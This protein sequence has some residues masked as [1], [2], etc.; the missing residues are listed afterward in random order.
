MTLLKNLTGSILSIISIFALSGCHAQ[1]NKIS[2]PVKNENYNETIAKTNKLLDEDPSNPR[3]FADRAFA[4]YMLGKFA[5]S[6]SD[7]L[8]AVE[9]DPNEQEYFHW[10][11]LSQLYQSKYK[12]AVASY[13]KAINL[14]PEGKIVFNT[15]SYR[16]DVYLAL[17]YPEKALDDT[18][19]AIKLAPSECYP[20]VVRASAYNMMGETKSALDSARKAVELGN[21]SIVAYQTRAQI[22]QDIGDF[23]NALA[24]AI[25]ALSIK[26]DS[27]VAQESIALSY[28]M[29][30]DIE[31]S[32]QTIDKLIDS[33]P[34][35]VGALTGKGMI[36]FLSGDFK[37]AK[38]YAQLA[39]TK[40]EPSAPV[41]NHCAIIEAVTTDVNEGFKLLERAK[42]KCPNAFIL[43]RT[44]TAL[45]FVD[46]NYE[47]VVSDC[48]KLIKRFPLVG[49]HY[50]LKAAALKQMG[51]DTESEKVMNK[52]KEMGYSNKIAFEKMLQ[53]L[54][55]HKKI[56][57]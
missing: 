10:L 31:K 20:Y 48:D 21:D 29:K 42:A 16:G 28:L 43:K 34:E 13:T 4:F 7:Y 45:H 5:K 2:T 41:L 38:K 24:D 22:Y 8:R 50:R 32:L 1:S 53:Q 56:H 12:Q 26:P 11:G 6:E 30:G 57:Q 15:L 9:L 55:S 51:K 14:N 19:N 46:A 3:L 40:G 35:Y 39:L 37:N 49:K 27:W 17:G 44:E 36:Y 54:L 33:S 18:A 25:K 23:D 52:A 47:R